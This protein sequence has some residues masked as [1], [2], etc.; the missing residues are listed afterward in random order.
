MK[1]YETIKALTDSGV[2]AVIRANSKEEG[3]KVIG[4]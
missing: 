2:V 1:K 3:K 4:D